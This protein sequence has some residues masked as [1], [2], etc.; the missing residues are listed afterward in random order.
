[1]YEWWRVCKNGEN[2]VRNMLIQYDTMEASSYQFE[3]HSLQKFHV[4]PFF[5]ELED[6]AFQ[7][8]SRFVNPKPH[9]P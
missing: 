6:G 9:E 4:F 2:D 1:M 3:V 5:G 8:I 7:V